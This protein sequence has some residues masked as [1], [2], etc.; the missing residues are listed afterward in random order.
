MRSLEAA[1]FGHRDV[2]NDYIWLQDSGQSHGMKAV[3]RFANDLKTHMIAEDSLYHLQNRWMIVDNKNTDAALNT[4][5][6]RSLRSI[7]NLFHYPRKSPC[8]RDSMLFLCRLFSLG[9]GIAWRRLTKTSR[10]AVFRH[11][12]PQETTYELPD[13]VIAI[14][15]SSPNL[16]PCSEF[17]DADVFRLVEHLNEGNFPDCLA[18]YRQTDKELKTVKLLWEH[19]KGRAQ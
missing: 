15:D 17:Y 16:E 3:S 11:D 18:F 19:N 12:A 10:L 9:H 4:W 6:F 13:E 8:L 5:R 2:D 14:L 7:E 1:H